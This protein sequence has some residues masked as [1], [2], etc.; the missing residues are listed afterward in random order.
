MARINYPEDFLKQVELFKKVKQQF[1]GLPPAANPLAA[2]VVWQQIDLA[3]DSMAMDVAIAFNNR[4]DHHSNMAENRTQQRNLKFDPV[5]A[6]MRAQFQFL[7]RFYTPNFMQLAEWGAPIRV[8]GRIAYPTGFE[9]RV[10]IFRQMKKKYDIYAPPGSSPLDAFLTLHEQSLAA[11]STATDQAEVLHSEAKQ[12]ARHAEDDTQDRNNAWNPVM[13]HLRAI[14][15]FLMALYTNNPKQL[16]A[17]G[18]T[19]DDSP[20]APKQVTSTVKLGG[21]RTVCVIVGGTLTNIGPVALEIYRGRS[22]TG[23]PATV[24]PGEVFAIAKG[25]SIVTVR[26]PSGT[27]TGRFSALRVT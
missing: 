20:R 16:G 21:Q 19:V 3:T 6:E 7:K 14:G 5:M 23:T 22:A 10:A 12:L 24:Q 4:Q 13:G 15:G 17:W 26:N 1:D 11:N 9:Q 8:S 27:T 25:Y 2:F 18:Y